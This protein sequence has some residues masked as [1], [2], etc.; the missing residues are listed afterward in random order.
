MKRRYLF[1]LPFFLLL[2]QCNIVKNP[3]KVTNEE[4]E[5]I[6]IE[7]GYNYMSDTLKPVILKSNTTFHGLHEIDKMNSVATVSKGEFCFLT[8]DKNGFIAVEPILKGFPPPEPAKERETDFDG[9]FMWQKEGRGF[10]VIEIDT[11]KTGYCLASGNIHAQIHNII[12]INRVKKIF[13]ILLVDF[14][15]QKLPYS[16]YIL[17]DF[18]KDKIIYES[19]YMDGFLYY[20]YDDELLT[21][22]GKNNIM[23]WYITD[24]Y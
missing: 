17:Y 6:Y 16:F 4:K 24:I 7:K 19:P 3:P 20:L 15:I 8:I 10:R 2:I 1:F 5:Q 9:K 23:H 21:I 18:T 11:K 13:L 22:M 12:L 14:A